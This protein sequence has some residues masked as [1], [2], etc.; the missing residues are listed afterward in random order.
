MK[1]KS[2]MTMKKI[3]LII[4]FLM[5]LTNIKANEIALDGFALGES[6]N[7]TEL[8]DISSVR[9]LVGG[10]IF[11]ITY[12]GAWNVIKK[13]AFE[14]ACKIW[15]ENLPQTLPIKV[16]ARMSTI[17]GNAKTKVSAHTFTLPEGYSDGKNHL[18]SEIKAATFMEYMRGNMVTYN[19]LV[20]EQTLMGVQDIIITFDKDFVKNECSLSLDAGLVP[21]LST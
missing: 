10:T 1:H 21:S 17:R 19:Q 2:N 3:L 7:S 13:G 4:L 8:A 5:A 18:S 12:E 15:A 6:A 11:D 20:D 16:T 14:Y 9:E